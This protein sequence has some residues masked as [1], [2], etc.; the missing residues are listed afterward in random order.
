M[1]ALVLHRTPVLSIALSA[2]FSVRCC[3]YPLLFGE[4]YASSGSST[5]A[6]APL[7]DD[8][9]PPASQGTKELPLKEDDSR[10][11]SWLSKLLVRRIET[12]KESH[13][14][15][16]TDKETVF[17]LQ[18]HQVKPEFME[19]YLK[20]FRTF[21]DMISSWNTGA[22]LVGSWTVEIGELDEAVHLWKFEHGYPALN[23]HKL[24]LRTNQEFINFK[25]HR[26]KMLRAR[27][28]QILL[29]F[30]F[31]PE[32]KPRDGTNIYEMRSYVLKPGTMIE[33]GNN[34]ARGIKF[35][36]ANDE[37]VA[38]YFSQIGELYAVHH[39]W[40][41]ESLQSRK[42]VREAAWRRPGWDDCVA[43][44]VPLIRHMTSRVL[45]PTKFSPLQ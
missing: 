28:N 2:R 1:A 31:W 22:S 43:H 29:P 19:T 44:T 42:E 6:A 17:E 5:P 16:L 23:Q 20:E 11:D 25:R 45:I 36:Q 14:S 15:M 21:I 3:T 35:R 32:I 39:I 27:K 10:R 40:A 37:T 4:R 24:L 12:G 38:G 30:S 33:W 7:A 18:M 34:W 41:Y 9:K 13:A 8:R 26:N